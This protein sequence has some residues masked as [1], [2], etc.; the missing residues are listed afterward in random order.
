MVS[1]KSLIFLLAVLFAAG[2]V[3]FWIHRKKDDRRMILENLR[4]LERLVSV[5]EGDNRRSLLAMIR[6]VRNILENPCE[7]ALDEGGISGAYTPP[8]ISNLVLR[9]QAQVVRA[10]LSFHDVN[11]VFLKKGVADITCTGH[12][13]G[14]IRTGERLDEFR[15]LRIEVVKTDGG[16]KFTRFQTVEALEK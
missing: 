13:K 16:W 4:I 6:D 12:L 5:K 11:I 9:F 14:R 10:R 3:F 1:R 8:E 15:E 2:A 7:L